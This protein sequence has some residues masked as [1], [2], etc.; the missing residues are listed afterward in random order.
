MTLDSRRSPQGAGQTLHRWIVRESGFAPA[1]VIGRRV[2]LDRI[3][4]EPWYKN[5]PGYVSSQCTLDYL[6]LLPQLI[7]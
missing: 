5:T 2:T 3:F 1:R 6:L 4:S 7:A